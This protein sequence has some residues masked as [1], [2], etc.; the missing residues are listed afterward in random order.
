MWMGGEDEEVSWCSCGCWL[1]LTEL[2]EG[3]CPMVMGRDIQATCEEYLRVRRSCTIWEDL[4]RRSGKVE[5][6]VEGED[7]V[8]R[9]DGQ[10]AGHARRPPSRPRSY[11]LALHI[12]RARSTLTPAPS[13][14]PCCRC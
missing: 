14:R 3:E 5:G 4:K 1:L 9:P 6:T 13:Q 8:D 10:A 7:G 11:V 2:A 12:H